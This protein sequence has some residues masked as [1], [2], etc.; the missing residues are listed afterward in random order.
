MMTLILL[1]DDINFV[2]LTLKEKGSKDD[3]MKVIANNVD[4][5]IS[6]NNIS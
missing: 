2:Y 5:L 1:Q 3:D 4:R 6:N